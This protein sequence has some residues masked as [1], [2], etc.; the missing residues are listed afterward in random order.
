MYIDYGEIEDTVSNK[1]LIS[2]YGCNEI[3]LELASYLLDFENDFKDRVKL[4][5]LKKLEDLP[6]HKNID[7]L[8][9]SEKGFFNIEWVHNTIYYKPSV[10]VLFYDAKNKDLN[11]TW[12]DF[13]NKICTDIHKIRKSDCYSSMCII[14]VIFTISQA[15][16]LDSVNEIKDKTFSIKKQLDSK[17]IYYMNSEDNNIDSN[18]N[19]NSFLYNNL[20][21]TN[22][23]SINV[24]KGNKSNIL[25][26]FQPNLN[27]NVIKKLQNQ[28]YSQSIYYYDQIERNLKIKKASYYIEEIEKLIKINL[29]L[30]IVNFIKSTN[31]P[32]NYLEEV[33][34]NLVKLDYNSCSKEKYLESK[35]IATYC[36]RLLCKYKKEKEQIIDMFRLYISTFFKPDIYNENTK[37]LFKKFDSNN[38][39]NCKLIDESIITE[40]LW[41]ALEHEKFGI[42]LNSIEEDKK[43]INYK[44]IHTFSFSGYNYLKAAYNFNRVVNL[45]KTKSTFQYYKG[46]EFNQNIDFKKLIIKKNQYYGRKPRFFIQVDPLKRKE[47][48]FSSELYLYIL[49][50]NFNFINEETNSVKNIADINYEVILNRILKCLNT[51]ETLYSNLLINLN[52]RNMLNQ[53]NILDKNSINLNINVIFSYKLIKFMKDNNLFPDR[54]KGVYRLIL[55]NNKKELLKFPYLKVK[56][57]EDFN[58]LLDNEPETKLSNIIQIASIRRLTEIEENEFNDI[59]SNEIL[60]NIFSINYSTNNKN[61]LRIDKS[62][63]SN[64]INTYEV[65]NNLLSINISIINECPNL[66]DSSEFI[67]NIKSNLINGLKIKKIKIFYSNPERNS[68]PEFNNNKEPIKELTI[69]NKILVKDTDKNLFIS[70]I[71]FELECKEG[72]T[73]VLDYIF[74][75]SDIKILLIKNLRNKNINNV[76]D[77]KYKANNKALKETYST[78]YNIKSTSNNKISSNLIKQCNSCVNEFSLFEYCFKKPNSYIN[79]ENINVSISIEGNGNS[80]KKQSKTKHKI[81]SHSIENNTENKKEDKQ[82]FSKT[83]FYSNNKLD[84]D[85]DNTL[86]KNNTTNKLEI[87]DSINKE[88]IFNS[89]IDKLNNNENL[90]IWADNNS[91]LYEGLKFNKVYKNLDD[92]ICDKLLVKFHE[93]GE[94]VLTFKAEYRLS[95]S[96]VDKDSMVINY[97]DLIFYNVEKRF[98][99]KLEMQPKEFVNLNSSKYYPVNKIINTNIIIE[100][101]N[102]YN[103]NLYNFLIVPNSIKKEDDNNT[104]LN[105]ETSINDFILNNRLIIKANDFVSI[106]SKIFKVYKNNFK[107]EQENR[108]NNCNERVLIKLYWRSE[109]LETYI[110]SFKNTDIT[111]DIIKLYLLYFYNVSLL[112]MDSL[113]FINPELDMSID[114][115]N[116]L[117]INSINKF[118]I[119]IKN[120]TKE[121]KRINF[122]IDNSAQDVILSGPIR[123]KAMLY[124]EDQHT[125]DINIVPL[126][127]GNIKLPSFKVIESYFKTDEKKA[128]KEE[129]KYSHY[130]ISDIIKVV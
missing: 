104:G 16:T 53:V 28:I 85:L 112:E 43:N 100:N 26:L 63:L 87:D 76:L 103:I 34:M 84:E 71:S 1:L 74:E 83:S 107:N 29:K 109:G 99:L 41:L 50:K 24:E 8:M 11:L 117:D 58:A 75:K 10:I 13:E 125:I 120:K 48:L 128:V 55:L 105:V 77:F 91:I 4:L 114:I 96:D 15:I 37:M 92:T 45:L 80:S 70:N 130:F 2:F 49:F 35:A 19:K 111:S 56:I 61:I 97:R 12:L 66:L 64:Y 36:F 32:T 40:Y 79:I 118:K 82:Y 73:V 33:M 123:I 95:R 69:K 108:W 127:Y 72:S 18:M 60:S 47:I 65:S 98:N 86:N 106:P 102:K 27:I 5:S 30:F 67:I 14:V 90:L 122:L 21:I 17:F 44:Y 31:Q 115:N 7:S 121:F 6:Q 9:P 38:Y 78:N 46:D 39:I 116:I 68:T 93:K 54:L 88:Y 129:K 22:N 124:P 119:S 110:N 126:V 51:S 89:L 62:F 57:L 59:L 52:K 3:H 42:F 25:N 94:F 101:C 81:F 20:N 23:N 113:K